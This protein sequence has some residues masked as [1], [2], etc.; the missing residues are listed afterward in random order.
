MTAARTYELHIAAEV[1]SAERSAALFA[2]LAQAGFEK[3]KFFYQVTD[4]RVS[5][6]ACHS[7]GTPPTGHDLERPGSMTTMKVGSF[8]QARGL[9]HRGM[10]IL[11]SLNVRGN[12]E[13]EG[14]ISPAVPDFSAIDLARDFPG[15]QRVHDAP[16]YENHIIWKAPTE[17]LPSLDQVVRFFVRELGLSP[18]QVVDFG[19]DSVRRAETL[20]SRVA[21]VYQSSREA[22]FA[23][24]D[25]LKRAKN[26]LGYRYSVM[27]Q[28][29]L[30]GE[31]A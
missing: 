20:V 27:E 17:D 8:D 6:G 5:E 14:L 4:V 16:L 25:Q 31:P 12:F 19:R 29:L 22:T 30:V 24:A 10:E 11:Q 2:A 26:T 7:A 23:F 28:V 3:N 1:L 21:T 9:I 15:Y 18:H 13:I